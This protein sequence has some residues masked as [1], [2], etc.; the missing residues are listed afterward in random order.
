MT[1]QIPKDDTMKVSMIPGVGAKGGESRMITMEID[2]EIDREELFGNMD[3]N[4]RKIKEK[5][6]VDII[7]R[8]SSLLIKSSDPAW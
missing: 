6:G 2:D 5:T 7:Q 4:I 8:G 3:N 1:S